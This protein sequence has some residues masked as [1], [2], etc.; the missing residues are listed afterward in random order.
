M[1]PA[2]SRWNALVI[3]TLLPTL[4]DS[5]SPCPQQ[6][7]AHRI[8]KVAAPAAA[9]AVIGRVIGAAAGAATVGATADID[10]VVD[11]GATATIRLDSPVSVRRRVD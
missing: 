10:T 1:I 8:A 9:G 7:P 6:G 11:P 3:D 4:F 5:K 2:T